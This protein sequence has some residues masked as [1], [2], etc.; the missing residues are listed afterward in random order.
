MSDK[1]KKPGVAVGFMLVVILI[2]GIAGA[3]HFTGK[4]QPL[5]EH[6]RGMKGGPEKPTGGTEA[7]VDSVETVP[8]LQE[9]AI[10]KNNTELV[11]EEPWQEEDKLHSVYR[12]R[13]KAPEIGSSITLTLRNASQKTGILQQ[14]DETG[15]K[16]KTENIEM[17]LSRQQL[18]PVS[19][20]RCYEDDYVKYM[21]ALTRK[22]QEAAKIRGEHD[23]MLKAEYEKFMASK[24][25]KVA[26]GS[27]SV[28]EQSLDDVDFK[29]WME[30]NGS[31]ELLEARKERIREYEAE[32]KKDGREF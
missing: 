29:A 27:K 25:R 32:R 10:A 9:K 26:S 8:V 12:A 1:V 20:A 22:R 23:A 2:A 17:T 13:F 3:L 4:L 31:A 14:L 18:A 24:G 30:K 19:L 15:V 21:A 6:V 5:L 11:T 28:A 16:I 7:V